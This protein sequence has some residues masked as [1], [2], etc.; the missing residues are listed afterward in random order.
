MARLNDQEYPFKPKSGLAANL[1]SVA[2]KNAAFVGELAYTTD[3][4]QLFIFNGTEFEAINKY[5]EYVFNSSGDQSGNTFNNWADL[6][7][8]LLTVSGSRRVTIEQNETIPAGTYNLDGVTFRGNG[9]AVILGGVLL[10]LANGVTISSWSGAKIEGGIG[11]VSASSSHVMTV[12]GAFTIQVIEGS[13]IAAIGA[14]AS[15]FNVDSGGFLIVALSGGSVILGSAFG[16]YEPIDIDSGGDA[17][18]VLDG[19][20]TN[21]DNDIIRGAGDLNF[22]LGDSSPALDV[23]SVTQGDFS[24]ATSFDYYANARHIIFD[25]TTS[26]FTTNIVEDA[27]DELAANKLEWVAAPA[28]STSTGT[29]GQVAYDANYFYY[30]SATNTWQRVANAGAW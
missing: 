28:T 6:Y 26:G 11:L 7:A 22:V 16:G 2:S 24:G 27:L 3:G 1:N 30:C 29:A 18:I 17:V 23:Y 20:G 14:T 5:T 8:T 13:G 12:T 9:T 15:L 25:K 19:S 10:T 4:K 21:V